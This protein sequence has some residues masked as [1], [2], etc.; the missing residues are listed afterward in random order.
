MNLKRN[1]KSYDLSKYKRKLAQ[2]LLLSK[3]N[4]RIQEYIILLEATPLRPCGVILL[5]LE[6]YS[7]PEAIPRL[8][9]SLLKQCKAKFMYF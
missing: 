4:R 2:L 5:S 1:K 8:P 3:I 7:V 9:Y 6:F